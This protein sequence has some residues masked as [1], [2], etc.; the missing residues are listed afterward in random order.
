MLIVSVKQVAVGVIL[1]SDDLVAFQPP[2]VWAGAAKHL[3]GEANV[4]R[5]GS[6][7]SLLC[8][9]SAERQQVVL[10]VLTNGREMDPAALKTPLSL[11]SQIHLSKKKELLY[12]LAMLIAD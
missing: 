3:S 2:P 12:D 8:S 6:I 5:N 7:F 1:E 11:I 9:E 4:E 10:E